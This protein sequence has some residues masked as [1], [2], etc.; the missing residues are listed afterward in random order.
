M[1]T[2]S[3]IWFEQILYM[4]LSQ[5]ILSCVEILLNIFRNNGSAKKEKKLK[6]Q[7]IRTDKM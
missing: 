6:R 4:G 2:I 1:S 3:L 5:I 7:E